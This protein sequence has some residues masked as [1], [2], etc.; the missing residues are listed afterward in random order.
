MGFPMEELSRDNQL[1]LR[2]YF[3]DK[4]LFNSIWFEE[5]FIYL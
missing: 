5:E 2:M 3:E 4:K 1:I